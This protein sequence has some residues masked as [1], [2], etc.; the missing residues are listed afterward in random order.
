MKAAVDGLFRVVAKHLK[1]N[2]NDGSFKIQQYVGSEGE[3]QTTEQARCDDENKSDCTS[4]VWI[5][6][7]V[8]GSEV[9]QL[10]A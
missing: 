6:A 10:C 5:E 2:K 4:F 3:G 9:A 1:E 7:N 8:R